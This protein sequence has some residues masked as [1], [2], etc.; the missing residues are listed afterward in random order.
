MEKTTIYF[1]A[2]KGKSFI[3]KIIR[4]FQ[5]GYPYTHTF[6]V[7]DKTDKDNPTVIEAWHEPLLKGGSVRLGKFFEENEYHTKDTEIDYFALEVTVKQKEDL[8]IFLMS[9]LG[10]KYDIV[11][12]SGFATRLKN[13]HSKSK[14]FCSEI[15]FE[16][17]QH[18]GIDLWKYT[19]P[20]SVSPAMFVKS[21]LLKKLG[22]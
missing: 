2:S 4:W 20:Q 18:V 1:G 8:E 22:A 19:S 21:P 10:F 13:T 15:L 7:M 9:K 14:Y 6:Y 5:W 12:I 11:G 3:S 16:G 17:L